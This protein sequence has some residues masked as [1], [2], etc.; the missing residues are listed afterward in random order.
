MF[1]STLLFGRRAATRALTAALLATAAACNS[2][3]TNSPSLVATTI[4][5]SVGID[6]QT[7]TA[8]S[9]TPSTISV[10]VFDQTGS[11]LANSTVSWSVASGGGTVSSASSTT[12][13]NGL[14][15]VTWTLGTTAG[16]NSL[17]A[18]LAGGATVTITATGVA[19]PA[20]TLTIVSGNNQ[21]IT[22]G[23]TS[24]AL[25]VQAADQYGNL[26]NGQ[27]IAWTTNDGTLGASPTTTDAT[28]QSSTT[29]ST[30]A[31]AEVYVVTASAG[32]A[33][34]QFTITSN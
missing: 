26:I 21:S 11:A 28:G 15:A 6:A 20:A 1:T 18:S 12:D 2:S 3:D 8:G 23:N 17:V 10:L 31:T 32:S 30:G 22:A 34:A 19:G 7:T 4:S 27:S 29:L 9:A 24:D 14:A 33:S 25:V 13:A 5:A 16:A